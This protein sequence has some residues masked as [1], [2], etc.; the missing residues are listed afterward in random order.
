[1]KLTLMVSRSCGH[2]S[3]NSPGIRPWPTCLTNGLWAADSWLLQCFRKATSVLFICRLEI[4]MFLTPIHASTEAI[5]LWRRPG[6]IKS[7][8]TSEGGPFCP[9]GLS[10]ST[11]TSFQVDLLNYKYIPARTQRLLCKKTTAVQLSTQTP[12]SGHLL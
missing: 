3:W 8:F 9:S 6:L 5:L 10:F 7:L 4:G 1:M 12:K 11:L 2:W